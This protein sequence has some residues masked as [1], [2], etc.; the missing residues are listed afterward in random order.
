L[1]NRSITLDLTDQ[2][3]KINQ[4]G[5]KLQIEFYTIADGD[6][7]IK[8]YSLN[9]ETVQ[10]KFYEDVKHGNYSTNLDLSDLQSGVYILEIRT[11]TGRFTQKIT[12]IH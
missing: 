5:G 11:S 4:I 9:G 2:I 3:P 10:S 7:S 6:I 8:L 1:Q 12:I